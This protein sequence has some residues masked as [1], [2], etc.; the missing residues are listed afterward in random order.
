MYANG[1]TQNT[2][3]LRSSP[4]WFPQILR[5]K[6]VRLRTLFSVNRGVFQPIGKVAVRDALNRWRKHGEVG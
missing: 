3:A 2:R 4:P 5:R 1:P 6:T